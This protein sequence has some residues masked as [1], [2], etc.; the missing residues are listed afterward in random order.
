MMND[1][2]TEVAKVVDVVDTKQDD[3]KDAVV[4][5][6]KEDSPEELVRWNRLATSM[7]YFHDY[8]RQEYNEIYKLADGSFN[9]Q[10]MNLPSFLRKIFAWKRHLETHHS[11]EERFFFPILAKRMPAFANDEQHRKSH[12][13]IHKGLDELGTHLATWRSAPTTYSPETLRKCLDSFGDVLLRHLDEEVKD[14]QAENMK[15][16]WKLEEVDRIAI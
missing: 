2:V 15:K 11:I 6:A 8:F 12:D 13:G 3:E 10:G 9:E 4:S 5:V 1:E 14:L 7:Q 16:Y